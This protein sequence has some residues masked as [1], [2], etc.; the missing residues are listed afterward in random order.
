MRSLFQ[1]IAAVALIGCAGVD[2]PPAEAAP[3]LCGDRDEILKRLS[4]GH[5]EAPAALGLSA[6]GGVLEVLVSP[7]GGWTI[8]VTYPNRPTC[9]VAVGDNWESLAHLAG[10][11]A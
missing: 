5:N 4:Q 8:I 9:V 7:K 1:A 3:K 6:D 10:Q 11:P 2:V